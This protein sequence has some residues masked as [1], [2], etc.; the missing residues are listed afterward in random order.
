MSKNPKVYVII[1]KLPKGKRWKVDTVPY[2]YK[3]NLARVELDK[4]TAKQYCDFVNKIKGKQTVDFREVEVLVYKE[5]IKDG[6][7]KI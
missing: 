2:R 6:Y 7:K 3:I 1:K 5:V 4:A